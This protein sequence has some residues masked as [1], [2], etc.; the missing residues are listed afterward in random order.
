MKAP[1]V[2]TVH[3]PDETNTYVAFSP[4]DDV[5][6]WALK[7]MGA[8]CFEDRIHPLQGSAEDK[9][10]DGWASRSLDELKGEVEN[11]NADRDEEDRIVVGGRK[12]KHDYVAAIEADD[13]DQAESAE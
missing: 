9:E 10:E 2:A 3:V 13:A 11:R 8:H 5:P 4:G 12:N 7:K 1:L 6:E